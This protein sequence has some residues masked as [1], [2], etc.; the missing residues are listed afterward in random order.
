VEIIGAVELEEQIAV[1]G[2]H[3]AQGLSGRMQL[4]RYS[5]TLS[6]LGLSPCKPQREYYTLARGDINRQRTSSPRRGARDDPT[7]S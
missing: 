2:R 6:T 7:T 1:D 5:I 3:I 4:G